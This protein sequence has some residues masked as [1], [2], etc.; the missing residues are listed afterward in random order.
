MRL[1]VLSAGIGL[2]LVFVNTGSAQNPPTN[3]SNSDARRLDILFDRI[4]QTLPDEARMKVDSAAT[5]KG[6]RQ[7]APEKNKVSKDADRNGKTDKDPPAPPTRLRELPPELK[8]QVERA[9]A[10]MKDHTVERNAQ[11]LESRHRKK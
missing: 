8:E 5:V 1:Q 10:D 4:M 7:T 9:M 2:C 3:D 11:F 6:T